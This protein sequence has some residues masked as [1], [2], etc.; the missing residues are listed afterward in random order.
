MASTRRTS[1]RKGMSAARMGTRTDSEEGP[2]VTARREKPAALQTPSSGEGKNRGGASE[3]AQGKMN[4]ISEK[5]TSQTEGSDS[6]KG[7]RSAAR[8][9]AESDRPIKGS[10]AERRQPSGSEDRLSTL[11]REDAEEFG[12]FLHEGKPAAPPR[13]SSFEETVELESPPPDFQEG[14][15]YWLGLREP[16]REMLWRAY[17]LVHPTTIAEAEESTRMVEAISKV[18]DELAER[19]AK[20]IFVEEYESKKKDSQGRLEEAARKH[21]EPRP[22]AADH[23]GLYRWHGSGTEGSEGGSG[24]RHF[25]PARGVSPILKALQGLACGGGTVGTKV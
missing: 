12:E 23:G 1:E 8:D 20:E 15:E 13:V 6:E 16:V 21:V 2:P 4:F 14:L 3:A 5:S 24:G 9:S 22:Y 11:Q 19:K 10:P 25:Q 18:R 17:R 7:Q